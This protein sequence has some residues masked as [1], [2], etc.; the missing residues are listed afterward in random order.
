MITILIGLAGVIVIF[1]AAYLI[2][3]LIN[4]VFNRSSDFI[5]TLETGFKGI[6]FI[7]IAIL[8]IYLI[9]LCLLLLCLYSVGYVIKS[10][11]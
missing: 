11:L 2:G 10:L 1:T 8:V 7:I 3:I 6:G 9:L 4:S 5:G